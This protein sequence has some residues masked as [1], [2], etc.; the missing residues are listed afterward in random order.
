MVTFTTILHVNK[1]TFECTYI[2]TY[3]FDAIHSVEKQEILSNQK[4][5]S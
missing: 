3:Y 2:L 4:N 1:F 5:I